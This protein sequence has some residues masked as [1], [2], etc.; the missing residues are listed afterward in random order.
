MNNALKKLLDAEAS[1]KES[2]VV[3]AAEISHGFHSCGY[4]S[5]DQVVSPKG[6]FPRGAITEV[7]GLKSTCKTTLVLHT[8]GHAIARAKADGKPVPIVVWA[9]FENQLLDMKDYALALG[10]DISNDHFIHLRPSTLEEGT[11]FIID[12]VRT[13]E[14]EF[15][16]VDSNAAMRPAKEEENGIGETHQKGLRS[17]LISE[18]MRNLTAEM[19]KISNQGKVPP[20][21]LIINQVYLKLNINGPSFGGPQYDSPGSGAIKF[22][23]ACRL[24]VKSRG[25]EM[26]VRTDPYTQEKE[27]IRSATFIQLFVEKCKVAIPHNKTQFAVR[28]GE[29]IDA[30]LSFMKAAITLKII[31][32]NGAR[33][34]YTYTDGTDSKSRAGFYGLYDY[35]RAN[36]DEALKIA[37]HTCLQQWEPI[38]KARQPW[39]EY[40]RQVMAVKIQAVETGEVTV[41]MDAEGL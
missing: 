15:V 34:S 30:L 22:Y 29:G 25:H 8:I 40:A 20:T 41:E 28:Y 6:L 12:V 3:D 37:Q 19:S 4:T 16:V 31:K 9:D 5:V 35:L 1:K 27:K 39:V 14:A 24:E 33:L 23:A 32:K 17:L 36:P 21:V 7:M 26:R 10:V 38:L 18:F 2:L 13:G 11:Q